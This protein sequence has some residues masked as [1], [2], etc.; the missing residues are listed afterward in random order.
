MLQNI[1]QDFRLDRIM[2]T[3]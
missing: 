2:G 3:R 1:T